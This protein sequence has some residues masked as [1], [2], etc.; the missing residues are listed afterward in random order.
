MCLA[1]TV[2]VR[3]RH[4]IIIILTTRRRREKIKYRLH[5]INNVIM[6]VLRVG[7]KELDFEPVR[8]CN[9]LF[10]LLQRAQLQCIYYYVHY[11][12]I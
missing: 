6:H 1:G 9:G 2:A 10:G 3:A 12:G 11:V 4:N 7:T 5:V 8:T